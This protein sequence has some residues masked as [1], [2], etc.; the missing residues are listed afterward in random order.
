[1]AALKNAR[2][3]EAASSFLA[4]HINFNRFNLT[5]Y[6]TIQDVSGREILIREAIRTVEVTLTL[7]DGTVG[8]LASHREPWTGTFEAHELS[9]RGF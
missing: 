7:E 5:E 2:V 6:G 4:N 8:S 9:G 1:M 3:Q